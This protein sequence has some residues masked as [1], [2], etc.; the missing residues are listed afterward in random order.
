MKTH[1][2]PIR[3]SN[4]QPAE[5]SDRLVKRGARIFFSLLRSTAEQASRAGED[6][7]VTGEEPKPE[8]KAPPT[9]TKTGKAPPP[10]TPSSVPLRR[11]TSAPSP[12][13]RVVF[14]P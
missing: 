3:L 8:E 4:T 11:I 12:C 6:L 13:P 1:N 7:P 9:S 5:R 10:V 14:L 2:Q